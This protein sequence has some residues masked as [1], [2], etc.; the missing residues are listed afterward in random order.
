M[1]CFHS[2]ALHTRIITS[3]VPCRSRLQ[4]CSSIFDPMSLALGQD[5][6]GACVVS[7]GQPQHHHH[8]NAPEPL[9]Q[10]TPLAVPLRRTDSPGRAGHG[11]GSAGQSTPTRRI[12]DLAVETGLSPRVKGHQNHGRKGAG[13]HA[14]CLAGRLSRASGGSS[15]GE[16]A[17]DGAHDE[18]EGECG[19]G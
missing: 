1:S 16:A 12:I 2:V 11:A 3:L 19:E 18:P 8:N 17:E 14:K 4:Q 9:M 7:I 6:H 5:G 13:A 10:L 15:G